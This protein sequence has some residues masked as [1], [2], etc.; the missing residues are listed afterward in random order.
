MLP[1][2]VWREACSACIRLFTCIFVARHL[3]PGGGEL[4]YAVHLLRRQ[5]PAEDGG[6]AQPAALEGQDGQASA[7]ALSIVREAQVDGWRAVLDD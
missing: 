6:R 5:D 4:V 2:N 3:L 7:E 1:P